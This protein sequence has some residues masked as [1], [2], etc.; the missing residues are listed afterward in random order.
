MRRWLT[1]WRVLAMVAIVLVILGVALWPESV[2]V[3]MARA[4]RGPL[5]VTIDEEGETRVR[6][7]FSVSAPVAGRLQRIE[8]EPGD[9][10]VK[11]KTVLARL[12]PAEPTLLDARTRAELTAAVESARA[13]V[14]QARAERER[15]AAALERARSL[16]RRQE[17]LT[18]A[19]AISRDEL[20]ATQ[21][22][23]RTAE[24]ALRAAD[25]SVNRAEYD[26]QI[27]RARLQQPASGGRTIEIVS[28][29]DGTVLRR[30]RESEAV[31]Q[32]GELLLEV[33]DPR[34]LE[35]VSDLL[36]T[37][38]VRVPPHAR[39]LIEQWGG[40]RALEGRVRRVEPSGFTKIS[41]LGVEEQRVNVIIDFADPATAT[42]ALGDAY[43][44]EVRIIAWEEADVLKVPVG[45]LFRRGES[46]AVFLIE[47]GR[48]RTH[49]VEIGQR[50]ATEAQLTKG[51]DDG[52]PVV[53][54]PPDTLRDGVRVVERPTS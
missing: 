1:N 41:A 33:G 5:Q 47:G 6:E 44:V 49:L 3:D 52:Q 21:T 30:I 22:T 31:V 53:L 37:D 34:H 10:V 2:E 42:K 26:L 54:H 45:S 4:L 15:A 11:G 50:N 13:A 38:A 8:L 7:R 16:L 48:A 43:R 28:P 32:A 46:W 18:E 39:V 51:L 23:V 29:I 24:E 35:V 17:G 20:E 14:G 36:S 25:F 12:T 40:G 9:P 27:A 19:G